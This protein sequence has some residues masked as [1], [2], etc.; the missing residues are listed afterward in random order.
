MLVVSGKSGDLIEV[1]NEVSSIS[2]GCKPTHEQTA[3]LLV[4]QA[5]GCESWEWDF[6]RVGRK[7]GIAAIPA[8]ILWGTKAELEISGCHSVELL[9]PPFIP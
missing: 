7:I 4:N 2:K 1:R 5:M 6:C 9:I 3:G 8:A